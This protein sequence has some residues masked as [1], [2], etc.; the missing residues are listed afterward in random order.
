MVAFVKRV[1]VGDDPNINNRIRHTINSVAYIEVSHPQGHKHSLGQ[2]GTGFMLT[3]NIL[4]TCHHVIGDYVDADAARV[5]FHPVS[6]DGQELPAFECR[7]N[8]ARFFI[9][10]VMEDY[11]LVALEEPATAPANLEMHLAPATWR[12]A[13]EQSTRNVTVVGCQNTDRQPYSYQSE[14]LLSF[15]VRQRVDCSYPSM[16]YRA[17]T[18]PGYSGG[19]VVDVADYRVLGMHQ[20]VAAA[21]DANEGIA[22]HDVLRSAAKLYFR[23]PHRNCPDGNPVVQQFIRVLRRQDIPAR[24][25]PE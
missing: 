21:R 8:P 23:H 25:G 9:T 12:D 2:Q 14:A 16:Q 17:S 10:S 22:L 1:Y 3:P 13:V 5:L 4:A 11:T 18:L 7:L 24:N 20:G 6:D 19:V 15:G